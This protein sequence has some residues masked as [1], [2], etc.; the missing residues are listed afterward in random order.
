MK[1]EVN[2]IICVVLALRPIG[3]SVTTALTASSDSK[4]PSRNISLSSAIFTTR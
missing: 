1:M 2:K 3:R 4:R